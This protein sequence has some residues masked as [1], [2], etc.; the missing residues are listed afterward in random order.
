[1]TTLDLDAI[2]A[3]ANAAANGPWKIQASVRHGWAV[4]MQAAGGDI[5]GGTNMFIGGRTDRARPVAS[6]IPTGW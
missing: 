2:E 4:V 1:M 3:R 5:C 6:C